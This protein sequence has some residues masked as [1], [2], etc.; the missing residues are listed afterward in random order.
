MA[1]WPFDRGV[2]GVKRPL[3]IVLHGVGRTPADMA[4]LGERI[5]AAMPGAEVVAPPAALP[6]DRGGPGFQWFSVEGITEENRPGRIAA[7]RDAFI[8]TIRTLQQVHGSG[9]ADTVL[10]GFSQGAIMALAACTD[11][12]LAHH[13]VAIAGR[14]APLPDHWE[15]RTRVSLVHGTMDGT[16][17]ADHSRRAAARLAGLGAD[18]TLDLVPRALHMLSPAIMESAINALVKAPHPASN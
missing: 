12:F 15:R 16:L 6:C 14:F 17:P 5:V 8:D 2:P 1:N 4:P 10:V 18:V 9:P 3:V 13:V 11:A 7:A